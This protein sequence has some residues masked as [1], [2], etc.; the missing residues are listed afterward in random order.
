MNVAV[1][2][3]SLPVSY[4]KVQ[5]SNT[6]PDTNYHNS[7]QLTNSKRWKRTLKNKSQPFV[8]HVTHTT[9]HNCNIWKEK[10]DTFW[11]EDPREAALL[12]M[13]VSKRDKNPHF[14]SCVQKRC[15]MDLFIIHF[16]ILAYRCSRSSS[17]FP[18]FP[19]ETNFVSNRC[20][21]GRRFMDTVWRQNRG[22]VT[23]W[24]CMTSRCRLVPTYLLPPSAG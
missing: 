8:A 12:L 10:L 9:P 22:T 16:D 17:F 19:N 1:R 13:S 18:D 7:P 5:D 14:P 4:S 15:T 20:L 2:W 24:C 3:L 11:W 21:P 23:L 6:G